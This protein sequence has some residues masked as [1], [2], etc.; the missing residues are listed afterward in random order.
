[1]FARLTV[2]YDDRPPLPREIE[3][4]VG[5]GRFS[6]ILRRRV[7]FGE[8]IRDE[9]LK[10]GCEDF[11]HL[12]DDLDANFLAGMIQT[13]AP[14][15]IFL[16][17]PSCQMPTRAGKLAD[18]AAQAIYTPG[19]RLLAEPVNGEAP[20]LLEASDL[21]PLLRPYNQQGIREHFL[22]PVFNAKVSANPCGFV[23][24]RRPETF[25]EFMAGATETR[26]FN[27]AR[28]SGWTLRKSSSDRAKMEAEYQ[29]FH[30]VPEQLKPFLLPTFGF[31]D[32]GRVASYAMERLAVPDCAMQFIHFAFDETSFGDL[33]DS[34][35]CFIAARPLRPDGATSVRNVARKTIVEKMDARL[36]TFLGC[37]MGRRVDRMLA[38]AGPLG[39]LSQFAGRARALIAQAIDADRSD[40]LAIGHG[41]PCFSNILF[42]RRT[43][44]MRLIDPRGARSRDEAWMHPLYDLAKFSHSVLGGY[45]FI[46][47]DLFDC[48]I[49][50]SLSL[51]LLLQ[52]GGPP[53]WSQEMFSAR[54]QGAGIDLKVVR[55]YELSL[56]LSMLPLHMDH[57]QKLV[58]FALTACQL[59]DWLEQQP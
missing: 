45:D 43:R 58:G 53:R 27:N 56:F 13:S 37:D 28:I 25:L 33:I 3:E 20:A 26:A 50:K 57:P 10:G 49:D 55:A 31:E 44:L 35:L 59:I 30:I 1:M 32:D 34:F 19:S 14:G 41:D 6:A 54:L 24:L 15:S 18:L 7:T 51:Q 16:R 11:Y 52:S 2:V 9:I 29:F 46:N 17:L 23:D 42:D 38:E 39:A 48:V 4:I 8:S 22:S 21:L 12:T 40:S 47:N 5:A 36:E